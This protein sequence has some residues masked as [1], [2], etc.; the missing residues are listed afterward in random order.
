MNKTQTG[1]PGLD[2]ITNGGLPKGRI[3]LVTGDTGA[4]KTILALQ[5]LVAGAQHFAEPGILV[6]FEEHADEIGANAA[7]FGWSVVPWSRSGPSAPATGA[8]PVIDANLSPDTVQAGEFD[9]TGLLAALSTAVQRTGAKR[10][11]FDGIDVLLDLLDDARLRRREIVRIAD[12]TRTS[13]VTTIITAK[14][15]DDGS[16][17]DGY[18]FLKYLVSCVIAL[19]KNPRSGSIER[20]ARVLKMRGSAHSSSEHPLIIRDTGMIIGDVG[21]NRLAYEAPN[22]HVSS[23][24]ERLDAMLGGGYYRA[25]SMLIS[26]SP[27]TAKSTL[28]GAFIDAACRRGERGLLISFDEAFAQ[29]E[30]NLAS[31]N[32]HLGRHVD[33]GLLATAGFRTG[34]LSAEEHFYQIMEMVEAHRPTAMVIDPISALDKVVGQ[35]LAGDL[36]ERLIDEAKVRGITIL[37]T[38]LLES[39]NG[40]EERTRVQISSIA[41]TW[42]QLSF[43]VQSG[44]RNRALTIIKSRGNAHSNQ[45]RELVLSDQGLALADVYAQGGAVLMG[46]ARLEKEQAD[47]ADEEQRRREAAL[48]QQEIEEAEARLKAKQ[49]ELEAELKALER[50]RLAMTGAEAAR[51]EA[52]DAAHQQLMTR[53]HADQ[54]T[55]I[56]DDA[57][58]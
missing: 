30:R 55:T 35:E 33:S 17:P 58:L 15:A 16:S 34:R 56:N 10:V 40:T 46:T 45:V 36:A 20:T 32:I 39:A 6:S 26:G 22:E 37:M 18:G 11:V 42:I 52:R 8:V 25:S 19:H 9:L 28:A 4:G 48:A 3:T 1:I 51:Q 31:V 21:A 41:D 14:Q 47:R 50:R 2:E 27:G 43:T 7:S 23:G 29:I 5:T 44:E 38:S 57:G 12:W 53:R 24:V 49:D 13:G 54:V